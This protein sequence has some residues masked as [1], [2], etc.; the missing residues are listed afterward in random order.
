LEVLPAAPPAGDWLNQAFTKITYTSRGGVVDAAGAIAGHAT[1]LER[2]MEHIGVL[3]VDDD[4]IL[5]NTLAELLRGH[6]CDVAI[7]SNGREAIERS[8]ERDFDVTFM[9]VHMP[10]MNG[11]DSFLEIRRL[12]PRARIVIMTAF[13][14]PRMSEALNA[15]AVGILHKPF[16]VRDMLAH[17]RA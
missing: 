11:I 4:Q 10:V 7:A 14:E 13:Q 15:G 1:D 9:D 8:R 2:A 6:D 17:L 5:A 16:R 3:I 12:K